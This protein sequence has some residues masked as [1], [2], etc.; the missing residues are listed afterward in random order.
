[1]ATNMIPVKDYANLFRDPVSGAIINMNRTD[2][3]KTMAVR[4]RAEQVQ[5]KIDRLERQVSSIKDMLDKIC[6]M[7]DSSK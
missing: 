4:R 2:Y 5:H 6:S 7:L 1:M 3:E